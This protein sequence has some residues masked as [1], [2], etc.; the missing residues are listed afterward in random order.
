MELG[1]SCQQ[2]EQNISAL[3]TDPACGHVLRAKGFV[4][5]EN[6]WV[7][8]NATADGL[9]ANAIPKGQEVLI[10][11]GEGLEK[12]RIEVRLKGQGGSPVY[13]CIFP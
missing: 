10:V 12:E 1:L 3:F 5:D 7:E 9:T 8:L 2:L 4:Q 13:R 6:G 11:I